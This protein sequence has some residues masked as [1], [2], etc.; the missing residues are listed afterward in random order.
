MPSTDFLRPPPSAMCAASQCRCSFHE[1]SGFREATC[2]RLREA[3]G[4][5]E[6]TGSRHPK[7]LGEASVTALYDVRRF[8]PSED[9]LQETG[10]LQPGQHRLKLEANVNNQ[11]LQNTVLLE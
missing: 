4:F 5:R 6:D 10:T 1:S 9:P 8:Q 7:A 11:L 3:T 2:H